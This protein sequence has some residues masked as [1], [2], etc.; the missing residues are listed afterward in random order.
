MTNMVMSSKKSSLKVGTESLSNFKDI[1]FKNVEL[2]FAERGLVIYARDGGK[3]ENI[4][5]ENVRVSSFYT[6][7]D[8]LA[9]GTVFDFEISHRDGY[10]QTANITASHIEAPA[11]TH[12]IFKGDKLAKL[13]GVEISN[14]TLHV[15]HPKRG[16]VSKPYL[17]KCK[18]NVEPIHVDGLFLDWGLNRAW[19]SGVQASSCLDIKSCNGCPSSWST[20]EETVRI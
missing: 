5:W 4:R 20:I 9:T 11:I 15:Q 1:L 7:V 13:Q 19:W 12:S 10:S 3:F 2:F 17:F 8:E 6:Y 14:L 16:G 18:A